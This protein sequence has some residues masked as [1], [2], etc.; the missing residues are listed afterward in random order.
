MR[1]QIFRISTL[2][3][4]L[5]VPVLGLSQSPAGP[6]KIGVINIQGAIANTQEGKKAFSDMEKKFAPRRTSLQTE[7]QEIQAIQDQLQRQQTT[8]SEEERGR[9]SRELETKQTRFKRDQEDAQA[10]FQQESQEVVQRIGQKMVKIMGEYA[11]QSG[12]VLIMDAGQQIPLYYVAPQ[13][14]LTEEMVHRYDAAYP[15]A[16]G[17]ALNSPTPAAAR[18]SATIPPAKR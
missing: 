3:F 8:M 16:A 1:N 17:A 5:G 13:I 4:F 2:F 15:S 6:G 14:D 12:F 9:L 10:D 7:Q 18:P 11:Q